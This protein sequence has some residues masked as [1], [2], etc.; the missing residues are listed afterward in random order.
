MLQ[1][2]YCSD[3]THLFLSESDR[4]TLVTGLGKQNA[5]EFFPILDAVDW[6]PEAVQSFKDSVLNT[7]QTYTCFGDDQDYDQ[8]KIKIMT[9]Y[10]NYGFCIKSRNQ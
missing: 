7:P 3:V 4:K 2:N 8:L 6:T 10:C 9:N 1:Y 5:T